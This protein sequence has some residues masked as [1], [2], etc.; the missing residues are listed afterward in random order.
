MVAT[1]ELPDRKLLVSRPFPRRLGSGKTFW[2][3]WCWKT[4]GCFPKWYQSMHSISRRTPL[5]E[6]IMPKTGIWAGGT[7]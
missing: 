5:G 3:L 2:P 1:V 6:R 4:L 7:V